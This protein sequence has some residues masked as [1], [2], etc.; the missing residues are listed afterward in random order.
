[1]EPLV[2]A[3]EVTTPEEENLARE[4]DIFPTAEDEVWFQRRAWLMK[5]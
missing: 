5:L 1:M 3:L 4:E 2:L